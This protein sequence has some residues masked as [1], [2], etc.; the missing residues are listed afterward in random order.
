MLSD[1][2]PVYWIGTALN[3][4]RSFPAEARRNIGVA[5]Y[6]AQRGDKHPAAKPLKGFGGAGVLE[7]VESCE[8]DSYR[9]VYT[10][11]FADAIYVLHSF[12]K[13]SKQGIKTPKHEIE[14]LKQRL[15]QA[16]EHYSSREP[17]TEENN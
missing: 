8:G 1:I 15:K 7:I 12:K 2:K 11:R 9:S 3:D 16:E 5:L 10:V 14:L 4:L 6:F 13:K 17:S